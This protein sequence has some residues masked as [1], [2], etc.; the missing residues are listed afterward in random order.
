M[1]QM[2]NLATFPVLLLSASAGSMI[3]ITGQGSV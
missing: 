1:N 2:R 3:H